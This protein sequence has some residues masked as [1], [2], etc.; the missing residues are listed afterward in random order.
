MPNQLAPFNQYQFDRCMQWLVSKHGPL[1]QLQMVK[2]HIMT[3]FYHI[4]RYGSPV[5]GGALRKWNFGP[6][7]REAW[8]RLDREARSFQEGSPECPFDVQ[9]TQGKAREYSLPSGVV[10]DEDEFGKAEMGA[11]DD[12]WEMIGGKSF[13]EIREFFHSPQYFMGKAWTEAG[14]MNCPIDWAAIVDAYDAEQGEDHSHIKSLMA[15]G[16]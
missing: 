1:T 10:V 12:A 14:A 5:I 4:L 8:V 3:D 6:V 16:I 7:V 11:M 13:N 9:P 2:L 15:L